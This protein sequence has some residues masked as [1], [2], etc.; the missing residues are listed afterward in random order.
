MKFENSQDISHG[1]SALARVF[2][3]LLFA[4]AGLIS[5][6]GGDGGGAD[7]KTGSGGTGDPGTTSDALNAAGPLSSVGIASLARSEEVV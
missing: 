1:K 3:C 6:C 4:I 5:G 7:T 2:G